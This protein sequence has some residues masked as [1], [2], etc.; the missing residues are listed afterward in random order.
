MRKLDEKTLTALCN[1]ESNP[2]FRVVQTWFLN[3]VSDKEKTL[4]TAESAPIMYRAQGAV[5][6]LLEFC[7]Y[8]S[9][10]RDLA[11]KMAREKAGVYVAP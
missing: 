4:R 3:S 1:L 10:P 6:E 2:D 11:G 9:T 7:E 8:A 5:V